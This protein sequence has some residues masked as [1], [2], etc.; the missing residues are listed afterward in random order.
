MNIFKKKAF[1]GL[2]ILLLC[3]G[4]FFC[5]EVIQTQESDSWEGIEVDLTSLKIKNNIVT[6]K[7][8]FRN[9]GS[10]H[11]RGEFK[12]NECYIMDE[13]NQK[14]YYALKDSD[15]NYVG[16]PMSSYIGGGIYKFEFQGRKT[17]SLW[18][19]FPEPTD[20]PEGRQ[21]NRRVELLIKKK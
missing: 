9:T 2:S 16:G 19:K 3:A 14:K 10:D 5:G 1:V 11:Q 12:F 17:K 6:V 8:K 21:Q 7:F 13:M 4:I 15:G 18:I 20:N